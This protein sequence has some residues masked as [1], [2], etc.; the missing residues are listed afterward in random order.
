MFPKR[1]FLHQNM[2]SRAE[3]EHIE[4]HWC[5]HDIDVVLTVPAMDLKLAPIGMFEQKAEWKKNTVQ[6]SI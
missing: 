6:N 5:R 3:Q 2:Q 1:N 4:K